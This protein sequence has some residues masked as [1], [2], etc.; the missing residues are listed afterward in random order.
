MP[1][2]IFLLLGLGMGVTGGMG[3][4][5]GHAMGLGL[6]AGGMHN[7]VQDLSLPKREHRSGDE[8]EDAHRMPNVSSPSPFVITRVKSETGKEFLHLLRLN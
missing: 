3:V 8:D 1:I 7:G 2:C 4:S 6:G 5:S